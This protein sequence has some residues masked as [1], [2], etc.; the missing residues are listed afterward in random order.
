MNK[1]RLKV[2]LISG[3]AVTALAVS[4]AA[5]AGNLDTLLTKDGFAARGNLVEA[6]K[7]C[8]LSGKT[9]MLTYD[10]SRSVKEGFA[11]I[12]RDAKGNDYIY[13]NGKLAGFYS[14]EIK[15]PAIGVTPIGRDAAMKIASAWLTQF[16]EDAA[17]YELKSFEEKENYGQYYITFARKVG[18]LFTEEAAEVSVMYDG[19]VKS[20]A[21]YNGGAYKDL[22]EKLVAGITEEELLRYACA[23]MNLIYPGKGDCFEMT[24]YAVEKDANGYYIAIYGGLENQAES[25]RY[26]LKA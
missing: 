25:V 17:E 7:A 2:G 24:D 19:A 23:E 22:S 20:V 21:V 1:N 12:Y 3:L 13:K 14:N 26:E 8:V 6:S 11:D 18:N 10:V 5:A 9:V 16:G 4:A 15:H